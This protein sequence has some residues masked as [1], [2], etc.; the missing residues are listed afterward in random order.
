MN[1]RLQRYGFSPRTLPRGMA[2]PIFNNPN[3]NLARLGRLQGFGDENED[4]LFPAP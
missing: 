1:P 4:G 3:L 2:G